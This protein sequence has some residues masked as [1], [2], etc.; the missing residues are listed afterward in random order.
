LQAHHHRW[1]R[2]LYET[3]LYLE[4]SKQGAIIIDGNS[5]SIRDR[6]QCLNQ[7]MQEQGPDA[8]GLCDKDACFYHRYCLN[9]PA[10]RDKYGRCA[11]CIAAQRLPPNVVLEA[12]D[13]EG[14]GDTEEP[15][16][17]KP[18]ALN[19]Q[20]GGRRA[21]THSWFWLPCLHAQVRNW[22]MLTARERGM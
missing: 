4:Q 2:L 19:S 8:L 17:S 22:M 11:E 5:S 14:L 9:T 15:G 6:C 3:L 21:P 10:R 13:D 1:A 18:S 20:A 7:A 16:M 12:E